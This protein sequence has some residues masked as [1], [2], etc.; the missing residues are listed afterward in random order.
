ML[1]T[2]ET[3]LVLRQVVAPD[4]QADECVQEG[5]DEHEGDNDKPPV[6]YDLLIIRLDS[7]FSQ[8]LLGDH[9][10]ANPVNCVGTGLTSSDH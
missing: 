5:V 9:G 8:S 7:N 4:E 1:F 10:S 2:A 3:A 6:W